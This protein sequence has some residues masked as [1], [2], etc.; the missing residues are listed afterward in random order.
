[1]QYTFSFRKHSVL[2]RKFCLQTLKLERN[3]IILMNHKI[4][5]Q[6]DNITIYY[7]ERVFY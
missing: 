5:L 2:P 3:C 7:K 6:N 4:Q 1:M